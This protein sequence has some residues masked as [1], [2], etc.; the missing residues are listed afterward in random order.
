M[1]SRQCILTA[2]FHDDEDAKLLKYVL[3]F[4]N[5]HKAI[6]LTCSFLSQTTPT[7]CA[8][9][10]NPSLYDWYAAAQDWAICSFN[11]DLTK[12]EFISN[13]DFRS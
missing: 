10:T 6:L 8:M 9:T 11:T 12:I 1:N 13:S 2:P 5:H 7:H 4:S 3:F